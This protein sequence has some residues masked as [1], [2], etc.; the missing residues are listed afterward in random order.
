MVTASHNRTSKEAKTQ[1]EKNFNLLHFDYVKTDKKQALANGVDHINIKLRVVDS[2]GLPANNVLVTP[3]ATSKNVFFSKKILYTSTNGEVDIDVYDYSDEDDIKVSFYLPKGQVTTTESMSFMRDDELASV[4]VI[5]EKQHSV[6]NE[7]DK[8]NIKLQILN[9]KT[10]A[11]LS[12]YEIQ[13]YNESLLFNSDKISTDNDGYATIYVAS[14]KAG[15]FTIQIHGGKK[16]CFLGIVKTT[17]NYD[18]STVSFQELASSEAAVVADGKS[19]HKV[20]FFLKDAYGNP[21]DNVII[22]SSTD[23]EGVQVQKQAITNDKGFAE[24]FVT[25]TKSGRKT[26]KLT[27]DDKYRTTATYSL[28]FLTDIQSLHLS[29]VELSSV[30]SIVNAGVSFRGKVFDSNHNLATTLPYTILL[31]SKTDGSTENSISGV[32]DDAGNIYAVLSTQK[33]GTYYIKITYGGESETISQSLTFEADRTTAKIKNVI[34]KRNHAIARSSESNIIKLIIE[35]KYGNLITGFKPIATNII[36]FPEGYIESISSTD[37]NGESI[38]SIKSNKTGNATV[39]GLVNG[40]NW[41]CEVSFVID[42]KNLQ[43]KDVFKRNDFVPANGHDTLNIDFS[44]VD[45]YGNIPTQSLDVKVSFNG[46]E[47]LTKTTVEGKGQIRLTSMK[48]I[49]SAEVILT[50]SNYQYTSHKVIVNFIG[51]ISTLK[52]EARM[53]EQHIPLPDRLDEGKYI[54]TAIDA[55]GNPIENVQ[56]KPD[57]YEDVSVTPSYAKTNSDGNA[58]FSFRG[59]SK[60]DHIFYWYY[61]AQGAHK[62]SVDIKFKW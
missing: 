58:I 37:G 22:N 4:I 50:P 5:S 57:Q 14:Q 52:I 3:E 34:I 32:T 44:L 51:D 1:F 8:N 29:E 60:R 33:A 28:K 30:N 24:F 41:R 21:A 16:H 43:F 11:A 17:F 10:K 48:S 31:Q 56:I 46:Q 55:A 59:I 54:V 27:T 2:D 45:K 7:K 23:D 40:E 20:H 47:Q 18:R 38:I 25:S 62:D 9:K 35:D 36:D 15:E 6:A 19:I 49:K 26:I 61:D 53:D 42:E 12:N 39:M 13:V